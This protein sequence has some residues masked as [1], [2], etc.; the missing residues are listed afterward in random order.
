MLVDRVRAANQPQLRS[1]IVPPQDLG[2]SE[3][4]Q[5]SELMLSTLSVSDTRSGPKI[6]SGMRVSSWPP[7]KS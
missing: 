1:V 4:E 5:F 6:Q 2:S 3:F 7:R